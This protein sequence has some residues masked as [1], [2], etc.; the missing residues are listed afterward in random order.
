MKT[1]IRDLKNQFSETIY[2]Y[3]FPQ[4]QNGKNLICFNHEDKD[5]SLSIFKNNGEYR[6]HCHSCGIS[7]D[8]LSLIGQIENIHDVGHQIGRLKE[9]AGITESIKKIIKIYEYTNESGKLLFQAVRYEPKEFKQ[10]KPD[11]KGGWIWNLQGV[12]LVP[13]NLPDVLKAENVIIVEGEKDADNLKALG[14]TASCNPMGSAKWRAEFNE[15]FRGK[16][17]AIIADNDEPGKKHAHTVAKNLKGIAESVKIVELPD[18]KE[19]QDVT[20][21]LQAGGTKE[22]LLEIIEQTPEWEKVTEVTVTDGDLIPTCSFPF[23]VFPQK[24]LNVIQKLSDAL[25]VEPEVTASAM[26]TITSGVLGN[27]IRVSPKHNY[28]VAL[29]I[30]LIIIALSGYGKS[31]VIQILLRYVKQMQAKAYQAYQSEWKEYERQLRKAKQ[32]PDA[33][34]PLKPK[35]KHFFVSDCTVEALAS[36]FE[37]DGRGI[38]SYQDEIAGLILGLDQ[39]KG[40]GNDRQHYLELFNCDSWKIDRK[41]G[42]KFIHNTGASIVGGIQPKVMPKVFN[43]DS[44]D[45]GMLPRFLLQNAENRPLKF[46]RQAITDDTFSYWADLLKWCYEIP[47]IHNDEGFIKPKILILNSKALDLWEQFYNEYGEKIPFLSD[48]VKVFIPKHTAY[49]SLKFAGILHCIKAFNNGTTLTSV[50]NEETIKHAIELTHFFTGQAIKALKLYE[51]CESLNEFQKRLITTLYNLRGEV[52]KS[53]ILL[54]RIVEVFNAGLPEVVKHTPEKIR[55]LLRSLE[56][57]TEKSTGNYSYLLW[58]SEKIQSFFPK[59]TVTT[60]TT[61]TNPESDRV[62]EV[63]V[64][65]E[66]E[67]LDLTSQDVEIIV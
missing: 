19:K 7:G 13:Y 15:H 16:K 39:Y 1:N 40:K 2:K 65:S 23:N 8:C 67:V 49:Y 28:E 35:L 38:I 62:T 30:W 59:T 54:T 51:K 41:S 32:D 42:V 33:E 46:S 25:H 12:R 4:W 10:R 66:N 60:V 14:L 52:K 37:S 61:V 18:L 47:L 29:F 22:K 36:V 3:Y 64:N 44:F 56:L 6:H 24:L 11:G 17:V 55:A 58:E 5:P 45:D 63:T 26:L 48:R 21:W 53:K 57:D 27:T 20:D 31:P 50:I 9:I 43:T 34:I